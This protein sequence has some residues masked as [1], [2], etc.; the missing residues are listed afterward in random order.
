M[1]DAASLLGVAADTA[2][3]AAGLEPPRRRE[4]LLNATATTEDAVA[5]W[6]NAVIALQDA[7]LFGHE[8]MRLR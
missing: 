3:L 5:L 6:D 8:D 4:L 7:G 1:H 2:V